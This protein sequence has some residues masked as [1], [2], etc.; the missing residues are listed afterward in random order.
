[1]SELQLN[2][3]MPLII[4]AITVLGG[5]WVYSYQKRKDRVEQVRS[6]RLRLYAEYLASLETMSSAVSDHFV[7]KA[8]ISEYLDKTRKHS[9]LL[10]QV[11]LYS[12]EETRTSILK[13]EKLLH[14]WK[15]VT[16]NAEKIE[17]TETNLNLFL[18]Q[19]IAVATAMRKELHESKSRWFC[20]CGRT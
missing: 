5:G 20:R 4:S 10:S 18:K 3:Y 6:E 17:D 1:M 16:F 19:K 11:E 15:M 2:S 12:S 8:T 9:I 13:L 7:D 14:N